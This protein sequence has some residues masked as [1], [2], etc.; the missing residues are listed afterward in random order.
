[1]TAGTPGPRRLQIAAALT[2]LREDA[3]LTQAKLAKIVGMGTSSVNRYEDAFDSAGIR[4][5]VVRDL[6][7][8]CGAGA[9]LVATLVEFAKEE[10]S[11]RDSLLVLEGPDAT[12]ISPLVRLELNADYEHVFA[13]NIIPGSLQTRDYAMA[14][15]Q[16]IQ[17][18]VP[19]RRV[20]ERV[21]ARMLRQALIEERVTPLHLWVV[22]GEGALRQLIGGR[23]VM[24]EQLAHLCR[25]ATQPN[26]DIQVLP[27]S[28]GAHALGSGHFLT[29][30]GTDG[31]WAVVYIEQLVGGLYLHKPG[32]VAPHTL[33]FEYLREQALSRADALEFMSR[34]AHEEYA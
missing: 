17:V 28:A 31:S 6:A 5:Q 23:A 20:E 19:S 2:Q 34:M 29:V 1:M 14:V 8:A 9:E 13:P 3:G 30:G 24:R 7:G 4:W 18:R 33:A 10:K 27:F 11:Q 26:I 21:E 15:H 12:G 22:L 16:G 25:A 32:Q